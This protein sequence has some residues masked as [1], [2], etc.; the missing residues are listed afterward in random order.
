MSHEELV[1]RLENLSTQYS[2]VQKEE[3]KNVNGLF[4]NLSEKIKGQ[5]GNALEYGPFLIKYHKDSAKN[6]KKH[7]AGSIVKWNDK[8]Q[9]GWELTQIA[10]EASNLDCKLEGPFP[11]KFEELVPSALD[12]K[13]KG[14]Y[15]QKF[16]KVSHS[17][18]SASIKNGV[19][20]DVR[21]IIHSYMGAL[22]RGADIS[23]TMG[24]FV[25]LFPKY[26]THG[27]P[28]TNDI[29]E[30]HSLLMADLILTQEKFGFNHIIDN[31]ETN[32]F[33]TIN[34]HYSL[35]HIP[36]D[37]R[38]IQSPNDDSFFLHY[39]KPHTFHQAID[40]NSTREWIEITHE[41]KI[42]EN[43][44]KA[45]RKEYALV[46]HAFTRFDKYKNEKQPSYIEEGD[47]YIGMSPEKIRE[48]DNFENYYSLQ[49]K[50]LKE[51]QEKAS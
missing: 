26:S 46:E 13:P 35:F 14:Q 19:D 34:F 6:A 3:E 49:L 17:D 24:P 41:G 37:M 47:D 7:S 39:E 12:A 44:I 10:G 4:S 16:G 25:C 18:I 27:I 51:S 45:I 11:Q 20:E 32:E 1:K 8:L 50:W 28:D 42:S 38:L 21:N 43:D 15:P 40:D 5:R 23:I 48:M 2:E 36:G 29:I 9:D 22:H 30:Q 31:V 33:T